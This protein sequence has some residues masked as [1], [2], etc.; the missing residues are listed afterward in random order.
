MNRSFHSCGVAS[1]EL[2]SV[3]LWRMMQVSLAHR[4]SQDLPGRNRS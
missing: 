3:V 4:L 2:E 1:V